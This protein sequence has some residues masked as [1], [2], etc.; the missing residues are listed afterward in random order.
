MPDKTL[1]QFIEEHRA[2]IDAAIAGALKKDAN[3]IPT[4]RER[5]MWILNDEGLYWWARAEGVKI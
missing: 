5:R 1:E 4:D 3:P 2:E